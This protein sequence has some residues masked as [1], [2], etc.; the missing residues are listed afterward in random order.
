M[1]EASE[2]LEFGAVRAALRGRTQTP[3]G[4]AVI[5]QLAPAARI[6]EARERVEGLRQARALLDGPEPP[7]VWGA[8]DV[9]APPTTG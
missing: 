5:G 7:P 8:P 9:E 4:A 1:E 3:L 6:D 2:R